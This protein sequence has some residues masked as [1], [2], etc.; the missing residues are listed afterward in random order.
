MWRV[1]LGSNTGRPHYHVILFGLE[2]SDFNFNRIGDPEGR[3]DITGSRLFR[4]GV[5]EL[6]QEYFGC[7]WLAN[8]VWKHGNVC[9]SKVSWKTCAY[10]AR[11]VKKKETGLFQDCLKEKFQEPEYSVMSRN[12]G[13]G[14]YYPEEHPDQ[15]NQSIVYLSDHEDV[16]TVRYPSVFL[17]WLYENDRAIYNELKSERKKFNHDRELT[18]LENIDLYSMEMYE[19]S[20]NQINEE[21]KV[22]DFYRGL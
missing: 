18:A 7:D 8:D 2:L 9:L 3:F 14:M 19:I 6:G 21:R 16:I 15:V 10:V 17:N 22:I 13:I 4:V 1:W 20:E 5:N 11:Y 12:P